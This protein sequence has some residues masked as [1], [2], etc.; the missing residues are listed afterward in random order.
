MYHIAD[1]VNLSHLPLSPSLSLPPS[2][3]FLFCLSLS[4]C[5]CWFLNLS[6]I[7][8]LVWG[9]IYL[10]GMW[11]TQ[12][13]EPDI[14]FWQFWRLE[15]PR[16][17][18]WQIQHV[19]RTHFLIHRCFLVPCVLT[20]WKGQGSTPQFLARA[21]IPFMWTLPLWLNHLLKT[22]FLIPSHWEFG[23]QHMNFKATQT[24]SL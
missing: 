18:C 22:H 16:S 2:L 10:W 3:S 21:L 4:S 6:L 12:S 20:R 13:S 11:S 14:C 1:G 24:L 17:R 19:L 8:V 15:S 5:S 7:F 23:F 9:Y